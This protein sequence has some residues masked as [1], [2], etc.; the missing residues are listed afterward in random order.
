[1]KFNMEPELTDYQEKE[2]VPYCGD[3][4]IWYDADDHPNCPICMAEDAYAELT[5]DAKIHMYHMM[6]AWEKDKVFM[7]VL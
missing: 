2:N 3:C 4:E 6:V 7:R 5:E 1:M